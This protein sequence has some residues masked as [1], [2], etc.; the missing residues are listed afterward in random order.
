MKLWTAPGTFTKAKRATLIG[1]RLYIAGTPRGLEAL[2]SAD[3]IQVWKHNGVGPVNEAP[4]KYLNDLMI[5]EGGR[6]VR[7]RMKDGYE[8]SRSKTRIGAITP[9]FAARNIWE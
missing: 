5:V 4:V 1:D 8:Q 3:G 9:L 6:F 2:D 7:L